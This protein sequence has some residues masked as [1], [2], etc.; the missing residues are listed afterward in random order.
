MSLIK[1]VCI[2][3]LA[4]VSLTSLS[5]V[6]QTRREEWRMIILWVMRLLRLEV[7]WSPAV[8]NAT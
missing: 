2:G 4:R 8:C 3:V 7:L 5:A 6:C 1:G